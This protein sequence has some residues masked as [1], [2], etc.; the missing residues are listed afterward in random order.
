MRS[1]D[2]YD[3]PGGDGECGAEPDGM[4]SSPATQLAGSF[5]GAASSAHWSG[6]GT[7]VPNRFVLNPVYTPTRGRD[8]GGHCDGDANDRRSGRALRAGERVDDDHHQSAVADYRSA[9][10]PDQLCRFAG[11]LHRGRLGHGLALSVAGEHR[12]RCE[13]RRHH[14]PGTVVPATFPTN[15]SYTIPATTVEMSSY[16]FRALVSSLGC[17]GSTHV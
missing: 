6:A 17:P 3:Q 1:D 10:Q 7:F 8:Y 14:V 15:A 5:G 12:W 13:L 16:Q 9:G 11:D 2:D 4:P